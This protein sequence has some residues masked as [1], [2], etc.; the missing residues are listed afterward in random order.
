MTSRIRISL[1]TIVGVPILAF[2]AILF[3]GLMYLLVCA[4]LMAI[5]LIAGSF[6]LAGV[7]FEAA[8]FPNGGDH[9]LAII[10]DGIRYCAAGILTRACT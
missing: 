9:D 2:A 10:I 5:V 8:P 1:H 7:T 3:S 6:T 4:S